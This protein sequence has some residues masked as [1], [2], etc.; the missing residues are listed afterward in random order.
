MKHAGELLQIIRKEKSI[1]QHDFSLAVG[2]SQSVI[3]EIES[4]KRHLSGKYIR[5]IEDAYLLSDTEIK[6]LKQQAITDNA[7]EEYGIELNEYFI[8][9][10]ES[11]EANIDLIQHL[12]VSRN[13]AL[14]E[15]II[16]QQIMRLEEIKKKYPSDKRRINILI[17]KAIIERLE[18]LRHTKTPKEIMSVSH[19]DLVHLKTIAPFLVDIPELHD[20]A[21][22]LPVVLRYVANKLFDSNS[23]LN[24]LTEITTPNSIR[25]TAR[26]TLLND[27][28]LY[29]NGYLSHTD[30]LN[31][32]K[33]AEQLVG[34]ILASNYLSEVDCISIYEAF[35]FGYTIL[36]LNDNNNFLNKAKEIYIQGNREK[37]RIMEGL[38]IRTELFGLMKNENENISSIVSLSE[39][40][41]NISKNLLYKRQRGQIIQLLNTSNSKVIREYIDHL[42]H[43]S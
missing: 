22:M 30:A 26:A 8:A 3:N 12:R 36:G 9:P 5:K 21:L 16:P 10:L 34:K 29:K 24:V 1:N 19:E 38:L 28:I 13:I 2:I 18:T 4:G 39:H 15:D 27:V 17:A 31:R 6:L 41:I 20:M 40:A 11:L 42:I 7:Q 32:F 14:A 23:L 43:I 37:L 35:S 33:K 25:I